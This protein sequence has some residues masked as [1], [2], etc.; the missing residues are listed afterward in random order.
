MEKLLVIP[1]V[2]QLNVRVRSHELAK[3]LAGAYDV[4]YLHW[5]TLP[6]P[7]AG[8]GAL[9]RRSS[10]LWREANQ[11]L[12][13][14]LNTPPSGT[15]IRYVTAPLL[16]RPRMGRLGFN[17]RAVEKLCR[18]EGITMILN[19]S[20]AFHM[21]AGLEG[22][23]SVYDLVDDHL[24]LAAPASRPVIGRVLEHELRNSAA[25]VTIS[26]ALTAMI[27]EQFGRPSA[28][29][30]NGV[31]F[32][33]MTAVQPGEVEGL[34][35]QLGL[36]GRFIFGCIGNHGSWSGMKLLLDAFAMVRARMP[37]AVLLVVGPGAEVDKYRGL[38]DDAIRFTGPVPPAE[39]YKYFHLIHAGTLPF[40]LLPFTENALPIKVLEYGASQKWTLATPLKELKTLALPGVQFIEPRADAWAAALLA[41]PGL[42]WDRAWDARF[43]QFD[44][45]SIARTV[46]Q[47]LTQ[48][49]E[50][51]AK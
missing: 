24:S 27:Q 20:A 19:A 7:G 37:Q 48:T 47:V 9:A 51:R 29:V 17:R 15:G 16:Y 6:R 14:C 21:T 28:Y 30:P 45:K 41:A 31:D 33:Q 5:S 22:I 1:H 38:A 8:Q 46:Q 34:R 49:R 3:A 23:T 36:G 2:E 35:V 32:E 4:Y 44:W 40:D 11:A 13:R 42:K 26:H 10:Q 39:V 12:G 18:R 43:R 50:G 25:I